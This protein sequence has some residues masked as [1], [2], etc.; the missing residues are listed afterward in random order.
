M[1]NEIDLDF[2]NLL[3]KLSDNFH[4]NEEINEEIY[5]KLKQFYSQIKR[6][7]YSV[8]SQ[9]VFNQE[10]EKN[11]CLEY[12]LYY[13]V[14]KAES[15]NTIYKKNFKKLYDHLRLSM[16][17]KKYIDEH[18]EQ[19][20]NK[21]KQTEEIFLEAF[22]TTS[23]TLEAID[24]KAER[25]AEKQKDFLEKQSETF[26][27][28]MYKFEQRLKKIYSDF[29]AILGIFSAVIFAAFGGLE[30]LKNIL[31][32]IVLVPT[33]K[34][35][36]FSSLTVGG[37]VSLVFLLLNGLSKLTGLSLRSC[38]CESDEEC[39]CNVV[40]KHPTLVIIYQVL[41]F[42]A[43]IGITEYFIDYNAIFI[44]IMDNY[45]AWIQLLI[46]L[47]LSTLFI[48]SSFLWFKCKR[49]QKK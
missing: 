40:Q 3:L 28:K 11:E 47:G 17:Q 6:H 25:Q 48:I 39:N 2:S 14:Q 44:E 21:Q 27:S 31:G 41:L 45:E 23:A 29:V 32:N 5:Q 34:L 18:L 8:I 24:S 37:I 49:N 4:R 15:S 10:D 16:N 42:I 30:I 46:V 43:L 20:R 7:E 13:I 26:S 19:L 9:I 12:N 33:G 36:L 38:K 1:N 22:S 35:L